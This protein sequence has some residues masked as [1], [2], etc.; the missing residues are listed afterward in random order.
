MNERF[1][2][3]PQDRSLCFLPLSHVFE[4]TWTYFVFHQGATNYYLED[5]KQVVAALSEVKPTV[6]TGVPRLYEKMHATMHDKV[7][8]ASPLRRRIFNWAM[9][10][11]LDLP[12][13]TPG[14][15]TP[16]PLAPPAARAGRR[17]GAAEDPRRGRR[18]QELPRRRRRAAGA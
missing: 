16:R 6:M 7:E 17:A 9:R 15:P 10:V 8:R 14:G 5:P 2:V 18:T 3:G 12:R 1:T 4:R 13:T 11:G